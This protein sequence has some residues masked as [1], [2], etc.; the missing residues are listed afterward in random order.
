MLSRTGQLAQLVEALDYVLT[1][2]RPPWLLS[3]LRKVQLVLKSGG[4]TNWIDILEE[5]LKRILTRFGDEFYIQD[6][7]VLDQEGI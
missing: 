6:A 3:V 7:A 2:T 5:T 1:Y 4:T